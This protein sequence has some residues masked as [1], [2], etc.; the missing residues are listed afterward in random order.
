MHVLSRR[1]C[2]STQTPC[3]ANR[4]ART[5]VHELKLITMS[6]KFPLSFVLLLISLSLSSCVDSGQWAGVINT[7]APLVSPAP[8]TDVA[9][10]Q[11]E[12]NEPVMVKVSNE[13]HKDIR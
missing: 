13:I 5:A 10:K 7:P 3:V 8:A 12:A 11:T 2:G 6:Q 4:I 1:S 9:N